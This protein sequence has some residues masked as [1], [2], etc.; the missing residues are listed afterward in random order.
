[1]GEKRWLQIISS[2]ATKMGSSSME[3]E[4]TAS[5]EDFRYSMV[6]ET[7]VQFFCMLTVWDGSSTT[8]RKWRLDSKIQ[9]S[10][11]EDKYLESCDVML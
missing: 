2:W 4:K 5:S 8:M 3:M 11:V 9:K 10:E 7:R 6:D 1:M